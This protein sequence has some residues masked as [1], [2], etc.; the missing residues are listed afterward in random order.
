MD[1]ACFNLMIMFLKINNMDNNSN[2]KKQRIRKR[3]NS[4]HKTPAKKI[5]KISD[6]IQIFIAI[7]SFCAVFISMKTLQEMKIERDNTYLPDIVIE[8]K[9]FKGG[10][11]GTSELKLDKDYVFIDYQQDEPSFWNKGNTIYDDNYLMLYDSDDY[12]KEEDISR[13]LYLEAPY[14]SLKNIG[15]GTAKNIKISFSFTSFDTIVKQLNYNSKDSK[16]TYYSI[17]DND[18][19]L[20][21][22]TFPGYQLPTP[23]V[24]AEVDLS[25]RFMSYLEPGTGSY[26][27]M[28]PEGWYVLLASLIGQEIHNIKDDGG[29]GG[30]KERLVSELV[31]NLEYYDLQGKKH[32][33]NEYIPCILY[34]RYA[35]TTSLNG[36]NKELY[37]W[38][39]FYRFIEDF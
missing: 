35:N 32:T 28:L 12:K 26:Q 15:Q 37:I 33:K 25:D 6:L 2:Q 9:I 39:S 20:I 17:I 18:K 14:L 5:I 11:V 19:Y 23:I 24:L 8:P 10:F 27:M 7:A 4:K 31:I 22:Y 16:Y 36:E 34:Y 21:H 30:R 29:L 3:T 38:T 1:V 13:L